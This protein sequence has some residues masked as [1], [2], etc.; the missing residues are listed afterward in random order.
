VISI[1]LPGEVQLQDVH[2]ARMHVRLQ[3]EEGDD[4]WYSDGWSEKQVDLRQA[5]S[6]CVGWIGTNPLNEAGDDQ[7]EAITGASL[8]WTETLPHLHLRGCA[9]PKGF[10]KLP[11]APLAPGD[12]PIPQTSQ[13]PLFRGVWT[14]SGL[15]LCPAAAA[16]HMVTTKFWRQ[17]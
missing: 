14:R 12:N 15:G 7:G 13:N 6:K 2:V 10:T 1:Q 16:R 3:A 8:L 5:T 9:V 17:T 11:R 4:A